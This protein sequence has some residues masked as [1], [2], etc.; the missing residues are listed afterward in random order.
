MYEEDSLM[1]RPIHLALFVLAACTLAAAQEPT[2]P[3]PTASTPL[4]QQKN[5]SSATQ[6]NSGTTGDQITKPA[7]AKGSTLIGCLAAPDKEG[8]FV[9]HNMNYRMGVQILG[10]DDLKNDAGS[11]VK[12]TGQWQA[13]QQPVTPAP[14]QSQSKDK[15]VAQM[16]RF[17]VTEV[18]VVS[19]K[20]SVPTE[21]TPQSTQKRGKTTTYNA[22][23]ADEGK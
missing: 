3:A 12:L 15:P 8:R 7:D 14:P 6:D 4:Q 21:V 10:P 9:L 11:K 13:P 19:P 16:R 5:A 22:P 2:T 17:Q 20:C 23:S 1:S 18:E